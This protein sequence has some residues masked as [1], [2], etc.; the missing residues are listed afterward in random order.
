[1]ETVVALFAGAGGLSG[2]FAAA[3]VKPVIAVEWD[4][5][6]CETYERN[7]G[8]APLQLDIGDD[9]TIEVLR[10]SLGNRSVDA[11]I[12][13]PPCQGFSTAGERRG[14]DPRN[15]LIFNYLKIVDVLKPRWFLFE[16]VEGLLTSGN[17]SAVVRLVRE[18]VNRGYAVRLEKVNFASYGLP[19]T[20]KRVIIIGNRVG[21]NF[22]LPPP[23]HSFNSGKHKSVSSLP[24]SPSLIEALG[25]LGPANTEPQ[26]RVCYN[27]PDPVNSYDRDM[28][29]D[30]QDVSLH[31][32]SAS[33]RDLA[34][35]Q[36]L[37]P[38]QSMKD[39]P[40]SLWHDSFKRRALRRVKDGTPTEK[41]GGAP[42][43]IKRL[44]GDLNSLTITGAATREFI[45]PVEDRP[46]TLREAARL[47]SFP[48]QYE[49]EGN[50]ISKATQIG[51]AFPP[52]CAKIFADHIA[53]LDGAFG[54]D[55]RVNSLSPQLLG[56]RL[57]DAT[58]MS[59]ALQVTDAALSALT[60]GF[61]SLEAAE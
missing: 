17:G 33:A 6:A 14:D 45:H 21:L 37:T 39:L 23:S 31:Y 28:R 50:A 22:R 43:G 32:W 11:V 36:K 15:R 52:L 19:Q 38:G 44:R 13:G 30:G 10:R 47:Q 56:Y 20:R 9:A 58:G 2:G 40:E 57:T 54:S 12:G 24:N 51:N 27:D 16:N 7:L 29:G 1:M 48:D 41:R 4:P 49:F 46:L 3:G 5:R 61:L 25:G 60:Q 55:H 8:L 59:P 26:V 42:S 53:G 34:R 18:F 35:Y